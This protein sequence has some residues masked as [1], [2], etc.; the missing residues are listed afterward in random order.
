MATYLY[1]DCGTWLARGVRNKV[2]GA[3]ERAS[4]C[5]KRF[6]SKYGVRIG[7]RTEVRSMQP[8][9]SSKISPYYATL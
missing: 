5:T 2:A 7:V 4:E 6:G 3:G 9:V 1:T 8:T